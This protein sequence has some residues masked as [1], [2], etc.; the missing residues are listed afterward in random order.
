MEKVIP[1]KLIT[2]HLKDETTPEDEILFQHWLND[3]NNSDLFAEIELLWN[4]VQAEA[5]AYNPDVDYYWNAM[6]ERMHTKRSKVKFTIR[7][8]LLAITAAASIILMIGISYLF[9]D[10]SSDETH[11]YSAINGK[12][13]ITLPDSSIVWI[14]S[15]STISYPGAFA[16]NRSVDLAGEAAFNVTKDQKHPFIVS[17][18]GIKVRVHGTYFNISSYDNDENIT[19]AL[20]EGSVSILVNDSESFLKPGE[21]ATINKRDMSLAIDRGN[22]NLEFF[23]ANESVYF[24]AKPLGYICEYLE[25]WYN[26]HIE[27]DPEI[28]KSQF[29]TF[30]IKDDSLDQ[31]LR[32]M[33]KI[34]PITYTF[35]GK[36]KVKI[37]KVKP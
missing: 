6:Q 32:I 17:V 16:S 36:D 19:V 8:K 13:K 24:K 31:I 28:A 15:G 2:A 9:L 21:V 7:E 29:Y 3:E 30:T 11:L 14:N 1:W 34:N 5:S 33:S 12:S 18:S 20:K 4:E 27:V 23:W 25:K 37:M 10:K 22:M 26:V 35:D